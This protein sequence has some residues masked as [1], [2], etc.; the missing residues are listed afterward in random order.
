MVTL[1]IFSKA[2]RPNFMAL[3]MVLK[4][5]STKTKSE[6][7]LVTSVPEFKAMPISAYFKAGASFIPSPVTATASPESFQALVMRILCLGSTRAKISTWDIFPKSSS[8]ESLS[9]S[10]PSIIFSFPV[11]N[12]NS[13]PIVTAV[14][15]WSPV[16][17]IIFIPAPRTSFTVSLTSSRI[18]SRI[19]TSPRKVRFFTNPESSSS[20]FSEISSGFFGRIASAAA[21]NRKPLSAKF[22]NSSRIF[23]FSGKSKESS[24]I[25]SGAPETKTRVTSPCLSRALW[26]DAMNFKV[27]SNGKRFTLGKASRIFSKLKPFSRKISSLAA[28][29]ASPRTTNLSPTFSKIASLA[30][31]ATVKTS[32]SLFTEII[33]STF[34]FPS[35]SVPVLSASKIETDPRVSAARSFFTKPSFLKIFLLATARTTA[36][37]AGKPSGIAATATATAVTKIW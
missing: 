34:I 2:V 26:K 29:V 35:V 32:S 16:N 7:S 4:L 33:F 11:L 3:A 31:A 20:L 17:I 15:R 14:K 10:E 1:R 24:K 19:A 27:E 18:G 37:A 5:S 12:P 36:M 25:I 6:A 8:S 13:A 21:I 9:I 22:S 30:S 23:C 28:S